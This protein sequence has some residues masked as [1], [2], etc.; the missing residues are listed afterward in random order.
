MGAAIGVAI[1]VG[2]AI[3][4]QVVI[5]GRASEIS[6]PLAVSAALQLSGLL[7]GTLWVASNRGWGDFLGSFTQWWWIPLGVLGW[8]IVA[9]LGFS[10]S[11]LGATTTLSIVIAVQ[12]TAGLV[13]DAVFGDFSLSWGRTAGFLLLVVGALLVVT[14]S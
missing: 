7:V 6:H 12:L 10:A 5:M 8:G 14:G 1:G 9:A 3:A 11:S 4:F 2:I 13:A